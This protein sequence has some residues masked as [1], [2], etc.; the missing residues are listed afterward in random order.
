LKLP[1]RLK[2]IHYAPSS[3]LAAG[4]PADGLVE[5]G[6]QCRSLDPNPGRAEQSITFRSSL[7]GCLQTHAELRILQAG[8]AIID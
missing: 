3:L 7:L 4:A 8:S 2:W 5:G 1:A 6:P